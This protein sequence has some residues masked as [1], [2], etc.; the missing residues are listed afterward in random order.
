MSGAGIEARA[1]FDFVRYGSVWEDADVLCAAL[2]ER[3]RG[4]R[5][6]SIASA[7][8]NA[9]AL[10]TLDPAE[11]VAV[12]LS[13]AQLACL[14]LRV[15]AARALDDGALLRFLGL[16]PDEGRL[17]TYRSL[18]TSLPEGA[19]VFWDARPALIAAGVAMQGKFERYLRTFRRRVLPFVHSERTIR[20][21]AMLDERCDAA[22]FYRDRWDN[23]RWRLLFRVFFSRLVMGRM[24]RDPEFFREVEG[25][26]GERILSRTRRAITDLPV[27]TNPWFR[28]ILDGAFV[29]EAPPPW[30][31][32][33]SLAVIRPRLDRL[34]LVAGPIECT[35]GAFDAF[36]LSD[37]FE[38]VAVAEHERLYGALLE[39]ARAGA[40]LAYWN[41][42]VPRRRPDSFA[43]RVRELADEAAALHARDRAWFYG[44]FRLEEVIA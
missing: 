23:R 5:V 1:G 39:H 43:S 37:L 35:E 10:L 32:P 29:P 12:D 30:L 21:L 38:Y 6:L 34:R 33:Q 25:A 42:L 8:D 20:A 7:G 4:G 31:R 28:A 41:M 14:A 40:R 2:A 17:A 44:A 16:T 24:G 26:V 9:L 3:A 36:N 27:R 11:V 13:H 19:R 18:R 22:A 15:A